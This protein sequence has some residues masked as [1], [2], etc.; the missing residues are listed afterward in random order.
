MRG[1]IS[2][3]HN[4][5]SPRFQ[6]FEY[7][8]LSSVQLMTT[9]TS[10]ILQPQSGVIHDSK[11]GQHMSRETESERLDECRNVKLRGTSMHCSTSKPGYPLHISNL[12]SLPLCTL[13]SVVGPARGEGRRR[14][15][16]EMHPMRAPGAEEGGQCLVCR[17]HSIRQCPSYYQVSA[18]SHM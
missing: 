14:R 3:V 15:K 5:R 7:L 17:R 12:D 10:Q 8:G 2:I 4:Q 9:L 16:E 13:P 1:S 11:P 6:F 18:M